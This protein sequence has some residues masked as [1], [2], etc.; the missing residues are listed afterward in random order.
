MKKIG[1]IGAG[2]SSL[3]AACYLAKNGYKVDV[4]EKNAMTGGRSQTFNLEGFK[5]DMGPSWYW[6]PDLIDKLFHDIDEKRED[7]FQIQRLNPS[8]QVVWENRESTKIPT[9]QNDVKKLFEKFEPE[10]GEKVHQFLKDAKQKYDISTLSF[11]ENPGL[12][13]NE[14][15]NFAVLK[16]AIKLDVLKSVEKDISNRFSS[17]K[18]QSILNFPVLFLGEMPSN[19]PS[20]YT[21]MNYADLKLGTWYPEGGMRAIAIA[22]EKIAI[23]HGVQFHFNSP[24][25]KILTQSNKAKGLQVGGKSLS[26]DAIIGGADYH[27]IEQHLIPKKF[28]R[29]TPSYWDKRKFAPSSLIFYLGIDKKIP[30]L[31]HHNLFFDE[32]LKTHGQEIYNHPCWPSKPLFYACSPSKTDKN[33]AP[34]DME[35]IFILMPIAPNLKDNIETRNQ[36][37]DVIME[38]MEKF[39]GCSIKKHVIKKRSFCVDDFK[40]EY[41]SFKGNA[42]GL[43]NTLRQTANLKPKMV[44]KLKGLYFCGQLTVPGPGIPPALISGKIAAKQVIKNL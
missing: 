14:L 19:I 24:V 2:L 18:A 27:H 30:N 44:S 26:Y 17:T 3:Y 38:R 29:Y 25:Q 35:N 5:F 9:D 11:I 42:Y 36:Y 6:M 37:F 23:D 12:K 31:E 13:W 15:L 28:R 20:L 21:L 16:K 22:L 32:D 8:Y 10:G 39:C 43:A 40:S 34:K 4:F 7:Y 33:V 1:V 41:N